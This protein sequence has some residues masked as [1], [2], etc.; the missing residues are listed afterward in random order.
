MFYIYLPG[1][2]PNYLDRIIGLT[3]EKESAG[4]RDLRKRG[5]VPPSVSYICEVWSIGP[6]KLFAY[7]GGPI[8]LLVLCQITG[9]LPD[10]SLI[11]L[12]W[13]FRRLTNSQHSL[14]LWFIPPRANLA[15]AVSTAVCQ[16]RFS[17]RPPFAWRRLSHPNPLP[18]APAAAPADISVFVACQN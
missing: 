15:Q 16:R 10:N 12:F 6:I 18:T 5:I 9:R 11:F 1:L 14:S 8:I 3:R 4:Y 17:T 7:E 13:R 2:L